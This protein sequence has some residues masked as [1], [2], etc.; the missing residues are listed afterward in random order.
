MWFR[1]NRSR[2]SLDPEVRSFV[3]SKAR[4]FTRHGFGGGLPPWFSR[5]NNQPETTKPGRQ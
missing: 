5:S 3:P 4:F 1:G 2:A